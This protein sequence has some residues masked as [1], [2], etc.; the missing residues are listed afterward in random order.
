M[1]DDEQVSDDEVGGPE[2]AAEPGAETAGRSAPRRRIKGY[3]VGIVVGLLAVLVVAGAAFTRRADEGPTRRTAQRQATTTTTTAPPTTPAPPTTEPA[4]TT[5]PLTGLPLGPGDPDP[6]TRRAVAVKFD[7][8]PE[9]RAYEG[10]ETADIVYEEL[11]EGGLT[12]FAGVFHSSI[13]PS[14]GPVRSVR[15]TDFDLLTNL[16]HP[17]LVFSGGNDA[18]VGA[19]DDTAIE[20]AP[21]GGWSEQFY[22]RKRGLPA[23]HNLYVRLADLAAE[24]PGTGGPPVVLPRMAS[25]VAGIPADSIDVTF[26]DDT[27]TTLTWDGG[28]GEWIRGDNRGTR[29]DGAGNPLGFTNVVVLTMPYGTSP[30]D[31][32]SPEAV[33][34][35]SGFGLA[36]HD[37]QAFGILWSRPTAE[38]PLA[39]TTPD[40]VPTGLPPG[41]PS[42][43]SSPTSSPPGRPAGPH[44]RCGPGRDSGLGLGRAHRL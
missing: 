11:V 17:L 29:T 18:T 5:W 34:L 38:A 32:R 4:P 7:A 41:A 21:Q 24:S 37:G 36:L 16:A 33:V 26:S 1:G 3:Q 43:S 12:R 22:S 39:L 23:P 28:R 20:P 14:A 30:Y 25:P 8:H 42:S 31:R 15:S 6:R 27:R 10:I 13:P 44:R 2:A 19:L 9:V 40:G 35:G